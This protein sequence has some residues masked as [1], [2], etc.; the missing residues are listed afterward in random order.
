MRW[1]RSGSLT[2]GCAGLGAA[3]VSPWR[4]PLLGLAVGALVGA[5]LGTVASVFLTVWPVLRALWQWLAELV[6]LVG[7]AAGAT[8]LAGWSG[9]VVVVH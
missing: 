1:W 5:V 3:V 7:I 8:V 6:T 9:S 4:S 2:V